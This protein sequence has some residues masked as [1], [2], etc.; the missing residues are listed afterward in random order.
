MRH[1]CTALLTSPLMRT[2]AFISLDTAGFPNS[3]LVKLTVEWSIQSNSPSVFLSFSP[4][5]S[6]SVDT[7]DI[8]KRKPPFHKY[9]PITYH[10]TNQCLCRIFFSFLFLMYISL[11]VSCLSSKTFCHP[12]IR[13]RQSIECWI[14]Q[15][16]L[17]G[18]S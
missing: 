7:A 3:Q 11:W 13:F 2:Q 4:I 17:I 14:V 15:Y 5:Q 1:T 6:S 8:E 18:F 16:Y 10:G 9:F 12:Q